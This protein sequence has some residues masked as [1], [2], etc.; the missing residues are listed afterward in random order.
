MDRPMSVT[1]P[2]AAP[3]ILEIKESLSGRRKEFRCRLLARGPGSAVILFVSTIEYRVGDLTLPAGTITF[4]H[5][6]T[7]R[8]YNVYH[9]LSSDGTKVAFYFNI[10]DR[11]VLEPEVLRWRDLAVDI[12]VRNGQ[13]EVLDEDEV[14][15]ALDPET[16]ASL[17]TGKREV[18]ARAAALG[19]ELEAA[20]TAL[21]PRAVGGA[22]P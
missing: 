22:R 1:P 9:W 11:T 17:E 7:D 20:A 18:L 10:A 4:G 19:A 16:R 13:V 6:W 21:W 8:P 5:F 12:L 3:E 2:P 14:P 15:A